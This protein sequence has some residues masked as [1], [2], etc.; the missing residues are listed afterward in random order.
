MQRQIIV[1]NWEIVMEAKD[2][3]YESGKDPKC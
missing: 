2:A 1:F 3:Y